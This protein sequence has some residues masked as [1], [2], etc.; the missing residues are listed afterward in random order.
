MNYFYYLK[1]LRVH[2]WLKNGLILLPWILAGS[3]ELVLDDLFRF[4]QGFIGFGFMASSGYIWNDIRDLDKDRRH[5]K[6]K[7]RPLAAGIIPVKHAFVVSI[8]L[9]SLALFSF[10]LLGMDVLL[11]GLIYFLV[12]NLYSV[13]LKRVKY[14]D[15]LALS[16]FYIIRL[17]FGSILLNVSLTG[18]FMST[19]TFAFLS[20]S[21]NKRYMELKL[22]DS[23]HLIG[24]DYNNSDLEMLGTTM[25]NMAFAS[26]IMLNIHAF[27]VLSID[28]AWFYS[29]LN[30]LGIGIIL[31]YFDE[32]ISRSDDPVERIVKNK[33]LLL[34]FVGMVL[35]YVMEVLTHEV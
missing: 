34:C 1:L 30:L 3:F 29:I 33:W 13:R 14:L 11:M 21:I 5:P 8:L 12:N 27:F 15:I 9:L 2:H 10:F 35:L 19:M 16:S 23:D 26:L 18:W 20:L 7:Y 4:L 32:E 25:R 22:I 28:T 17:Y 31:Y 24:R 6:K